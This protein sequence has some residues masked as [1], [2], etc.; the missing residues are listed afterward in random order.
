MAINRVSLVLAVAVAGLVWGTESLDP[1]RTWQEHWFEHKQLVKLVASDDDV[2]LYFDDDVP[3]KGTEWILPFVTK[4]WRYTKKTY[5]SFGPDARL[6][7]IFHQGKYGG[8][9][10]FDVLGG[11]P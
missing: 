5:G 7:A 6:Y 2:A 11:I 8:G 9:H 10:P 1:P 4:M 3:R